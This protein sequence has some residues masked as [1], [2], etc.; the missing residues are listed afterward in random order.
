MGLRFST[1]L[2]KIMKYLWDGSGQ[3][4]GISAVCHMSVIVVEDCQDSLEMYAK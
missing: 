4:R 1:L 3:D 2:I